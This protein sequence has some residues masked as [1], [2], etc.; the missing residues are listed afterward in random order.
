MTPPVQVRRIS[1]GHEL[2]GSLSVPGQLRPNAFSTG[3]VLPTA[4]ATPCARASPGRIASA[5]IAA[6]TVAFARRC[7]FMLSSLG[8]K[9]R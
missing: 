2:P 3:I 6:Q 1:T 8:Q 7:V 4:K 9:N 5:R